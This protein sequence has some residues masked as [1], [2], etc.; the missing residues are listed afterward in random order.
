MNLFKISVLGIFLSLSLTFSTALYEV[1]EVETTADGDKSSNVIANVGIEDE[2]IISQ[3]GNK[4]KIYFNFT[5][6]EGL[7]SGVKYGVQLIPES[8][9][10][11][12]HEEVYDE[13]VTL[14][15]N[16]E[17][18]REVEYTAP[19][20]IGC[21]Y[22]LQLVSMNESSFPFAF[23]S[24]GK[25]KLT[26]ITKT[27]EIDTKSCFIQ[28]FG[29]KSLTKYELLQ[30]VDIKSSEALKLTCTATNNTTSDAILT[31]SFETFHF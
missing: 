25:V 1:D 4:F 24:L 15:E 9:D 28:V 19:S 11:I 18:S 21:T 10:Y 2:H 8:G 26:A 12:A 13:S 16:S 22:I 7:Q 31:P 14:Y 6:E 29:E 23:V 5:N 20:Y 30:N 27:V 3:E 17:Q